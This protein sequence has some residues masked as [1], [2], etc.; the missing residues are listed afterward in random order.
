MI[1]RL[2]RFIER[3]FGLAAQA[4]RVNE[5]AAAK[6]ARR[7]RAIVVNA[8]SRIEAHLRQHLGAHPNDPQFTTYL[9][10]RE[11]AEAEV[12]TAIANAF[13]ARGIWPSIS[14]FEGVMPY[15]T[16]T[17]GDCN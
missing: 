11:A 7:K 14:N 3:L 10:H 2:S 4:R 5:E 16:L 6:D 1:R 17:W 12:A 13:N 8:V 15:I 9:L